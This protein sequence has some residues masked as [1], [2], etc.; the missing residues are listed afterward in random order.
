MRGLNCRESL[1]ELIFHQAIHS[2]EKI[3][4]NSEKTGEIILPNDLPSLFPITI[5]NLFF[6]QY[7]DGTDD[8][9]VSHLHLHNERMDGFYEVLYFF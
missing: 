1:K 6:L 9:C 3:K 2:H 7:P 5:Q 4:V 8:D